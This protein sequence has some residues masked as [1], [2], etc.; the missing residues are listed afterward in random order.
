MGKHGPHEERCPINYRMPFKSSKTSLLT[1][2]QTKN[3]LVSHF[4]LQM[5]NIISFLHELN[6]GLESNRVY[7]HLLANHG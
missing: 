3:I 5:C 4:K 7:V 1:N 2:K 6:N